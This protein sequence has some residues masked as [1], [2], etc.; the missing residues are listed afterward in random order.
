MSCCLSAGKLGGL[1]TVQLTTN[2]T[3]DRGCIQPI[4][5]PNA[6]IPATDID[7]EDCRVVGYGS[8]DDCKIFASLVCDNVFDAVIN[9]SFLSVISSGKYAENAQ[10]KKYT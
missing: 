10:E 2:L 1:Y 9:A 6:N 7:L 8:R 3:F 5:P 4:C